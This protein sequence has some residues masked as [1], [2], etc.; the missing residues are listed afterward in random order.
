MK[1][2]HTVMTQVDLGDGIVCNVN[3]N[4]KEINLVY[5]TKKAKYTLTS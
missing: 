2:K 1:I 3:I 4:Q 5:K